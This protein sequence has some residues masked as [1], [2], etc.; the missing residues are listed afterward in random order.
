MV[1]RKREDVTKQGF[2]KLLLLRLRES[3]FILVLIQFQSHC[4]PSGW[5]GGGRLFE[6]GR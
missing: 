2:C 6:A 5:V 3:L 4:L 1:I